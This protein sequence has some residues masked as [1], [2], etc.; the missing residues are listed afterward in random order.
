MKTLDAIKVV[1]GLV[2]AGFPD[3]E[4]F[5]DDNRTVALPDAGAIRLLVFPGEERV[6]ASNGFYGQVVTFSLEIYRKKGEG[7]GDVW[8]DEDKLNALFRGKSFLPLEGE[9]GHLVAERLLTERRGP[10]PE[11]DFYV[12]VVN[13]VFTNYSNYPEA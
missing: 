1:S 2:K 5:P 11:R 13:A 4:L 3:L 8:T 9:N 7:Q 10:E 6:K 12:L